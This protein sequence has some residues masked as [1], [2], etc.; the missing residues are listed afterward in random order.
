[1]PAHTT[2]EDGR[3]RCPHCKGLDTP[4]YM[5]EDESVEMDCRDCGETYRV[6]MTIVYTY[7]ATAD[8]AAAKGGPDAR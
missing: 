5:D 2:I 4:P 1:M 8:L 7:E 6:S 3:V